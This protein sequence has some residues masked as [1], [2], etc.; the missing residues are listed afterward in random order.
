MSYRVN[1]IFRRALQFSGNVAGSLVVQSG[2]NAIYCGMKL[3]ETSILVF[4][5]HD[6]FISKYMYGVEEG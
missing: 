1:Q 4:A 3:V 5:I 6:E 2:S